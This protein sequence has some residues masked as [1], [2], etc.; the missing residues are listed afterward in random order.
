MKE[1]TGRGYYL[2]LPRCLTEEIRRVDKIEGFILR[3][4]LGKALLSS[5]RGIIR[6]R[7]PWPIPWIIRIKSVTS[8][9]G[10]SP[11][12]GPEWPCCSPSASANS[13]LSTV[14]SS[15]S[16]GGPVRLLL[17]PLLFFCIC[18]FKSTSLPSRLCGRN[19][20]SCADLGVGVGVGAAVAGPSSTMGL[21]AGEDGVEALVVLAAAPGR[22][23]GGRERCSA[24][25][26][27][28]YTTDADG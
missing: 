24:A 7:T 22:L 12:F 17:L 26:Y 28:R 4:Q 11:T 9:E 8:C 6:T 25:S 19:L 13:C 20:C 14:A 1:G 5:T 27:P 18:F 16:T 3:R 10:P 23:G 2:H 15:R 21:E